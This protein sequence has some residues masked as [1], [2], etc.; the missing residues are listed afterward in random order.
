MFFFKTHASEFRHRLHDSD[1][2]TSRSVSWWCS[3]WRCRRRLV[4]KSHVEWTQ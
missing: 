4:R 1:H 3:W 2:L